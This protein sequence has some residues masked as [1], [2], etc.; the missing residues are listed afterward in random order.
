M[1]HSIGSPRTVSHK[2]TTSAIDF[3]TIPLEAVR[4]G[5]ILVVGATV[6]DRIFYVES[7]P[8][9]GE[10]SIGHRMEIHPGGKGANQALAARRMGADVMFI[11]CV[12]EDHPGEL[13]LQPLLDAGV[14]TEGV[15][16][17]PDQPTAEAIISVDANGENQITACP[18]AYH[19]LRPEHLDRKTH[20][21]R[22]ADWLLIQNELPQK[23]VKHAIT[24]AH[25]HNLKVIF[26]PDPFNRKS[27]RPPRGLHAIIPN[28]LQAS[29]ILSVENYEAIPI[30]ERHGRWSGVGTEHVIVTLGPKGVEW[31]KRD[32]DSLTIAPPQVE[33]IDSVGAGDAFCG[34]LAAFLSEG[35]PHE[36]AIV[37]ANHAAAMSVQHR[38]A[39]AGLQ[40]R[41]NLLAA[42]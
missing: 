42:R 25:E 5:K 24:L 28:E 10:T 14:N 9:P 38:G 12:G 27:A 30:S 8:R 7:L 39:Q 21:F 33:V 2:S 3:S 26:N 11:S 32:G 20:L 17:I 41:A 13:A 36:T 1:N 15:V 4:P 29:E 19:H 16:T 18:G 35:L 31:I 6:L 40:T 34:S 37:L 23:A 22:R